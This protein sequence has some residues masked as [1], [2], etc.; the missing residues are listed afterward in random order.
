MEH[1]APESR[2]PLLQAPQTPDRPN[3]KQATVPPRR[4]AASLSNTVKVSLTLIC[5]FYEGT[6][7]DQQRL[8]QVAKS[9]N[10]AT[11]LNQYRH[12]LQQSITSSAILA[13]PT[14]FLPKMR[15]ASPQNVSAKN[16]VQQHNSPKAI[17]S[18]LLATSSEMRPCFD[19]P[20]GI[21]LTSQANSN[22]KGTHNR[23]F[24]IYSKP[25]SNSRRSNPSL[26]IPPF[27]PQHKIPNPL[28]TSININTT[29]LKSRQC[30]VQNGPDDDAHIPDV[31]KPPVHL[32]S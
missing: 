17:T 26:N 24:I 22:P 18:E 8:Y 4:A 9:S 28:R 27:S 3:T 31:S 16:L 2:E 32:I 25:L 11:T 10:D 23:T 1:A 6:R 15:L 30:K 13:T 21:S 7:S 29:L 14:R 20:G 19:L 5:N 12:H